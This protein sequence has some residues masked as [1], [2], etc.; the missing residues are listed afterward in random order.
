MVKSMFLFLGV[1]LKLLPE[2]L[3]DEVSE[4][5]LVGP[6]L[7]SLKKLLEKVPEGQSEKLKFERMVHGI[8]SACLVNIDSMRCAVLYSCPPVCADPP[9]R[10][11]EG[12]AC[13]KKIQSNLLAAVLILTVLPPNVRISQAVIE[14]CCFLITENLTQSDAVRS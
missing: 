1:P 5:D 11:R 6:T 4:L 2:L 12:P 14:H 9:D 3:K 13:S 10:G 8:A 7:Q